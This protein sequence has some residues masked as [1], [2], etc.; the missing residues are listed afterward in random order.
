MGSESSHGGFVRLGSDTHGVDLSWFSMKCDQ[1][2]WGVKITEVTDLVFWIF[3]KNLKNL[4]FEF[5]EILDFSI[6]FP[7]LARGGNHTLQGDQ[8]RL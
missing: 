8:W 5:F 7:L 6:L 3:W 1:S 2:H 4:N